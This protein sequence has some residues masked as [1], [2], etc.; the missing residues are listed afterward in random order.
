MTVPVALQSQL[1]DL[2][3]FPDRP[4]RIEALLAIGDEYRN[5]SPAEVARTEANRV[6]GC[7]SEVFFAFESLSQG[8]QRYRFAVDN[9]QGI[10][11]MALAVILEK[12]SGSAR[13]QVATVSEDVVYEIF[14]RE[15]SMGK[16][17][18]LTSMVR[19]LKE[20]ALRS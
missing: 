8:T 6:P 13:E 2:A 9:P 1:D 3:L 7:E 19:M 12:L 17:M 16:S 4:D 11:A 10:S 18:G 20:A 15:L 14:G 5:Y